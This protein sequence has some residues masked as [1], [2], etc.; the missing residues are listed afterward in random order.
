[1]AGVTG[2]ILDDTVSWPVAQMFNISYFLTGYCLSILIQSAGGVEDQT[3]VSSLGP[4]PI[5]EG[6]NDEVEV[7]AAADEVLGIPEIQSQDLD[8]GANQIDE[9]N[10]GEIPQNTV[11]CLSLNC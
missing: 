8:I 6:S 4:Q 9:Q 2:E 1:M 5:E 3:L 11:S 10:I 7:A